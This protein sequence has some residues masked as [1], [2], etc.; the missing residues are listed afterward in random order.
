MVLTLENH[1]EALKKVN[2][3]VLKEIAKSKNLVAPNYY[4]Y[5]NLKSM[6]AIAERHKIGFELLCF[7]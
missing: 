6:T 5:P 4:R 7:S 1:G 2:P 3:D